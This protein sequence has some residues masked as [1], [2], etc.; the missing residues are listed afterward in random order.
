MLTCLTGQHVTIARLASPLSR[1]DLRA[2][3]RR[4]E[5]VMGILQEID[6]RG[7][8]YRELRIRSHNI[9]NR[10]PSLLVVD[11]YFQLKCG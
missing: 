11:L 5:R 4:P 8:T 10:T 1:E 2:I 9:Y 7:S 6:R 3:F